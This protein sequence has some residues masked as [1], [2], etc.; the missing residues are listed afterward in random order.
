[1]ENPWAT[2]TIDPHDSSS[3]VAESNR[4][5]A[6]L[7]DPLHYTQTNLAKLLGFT[8]TATS[9]AS[10]DAQ[11]DSLNGHKSQNSQP[12]K[13]V[14]MESPWATATIDPHDSFQT[15]TPFKIDAGGAI[16][17]M[18]V[19]RSMSPTPTDTPELSRSS[20]VCSDGSVGFDTDST[21]SGEESD[22]EDDGFDP[23]E[24]LAQTIQD[25]EVAVNR[26]NGEQK[27]QRDNETIIDS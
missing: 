7:V 9:K 1:M 20:S 16:S 25:S 4:E 17:D 11:L 23:N 12:P 18:N 19:Y 27:R 10:A 15:F 3:K 14:I 6:Y 21:W 26:D 2:A 22:W 8:D 24:L 5:S 13:Q